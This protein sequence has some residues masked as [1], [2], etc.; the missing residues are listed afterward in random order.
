MGCA[1]C[2]GRGISGARVRAT[3]EQKHTLWPW[4]A[5]ELFGKLEHMLRVA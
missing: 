5:H 2:S 4:I 3:S 1:R